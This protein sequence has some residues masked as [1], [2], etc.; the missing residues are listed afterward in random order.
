MRN[1][2]MDVAIH[3]TKFLEPGE[4]VLDIGSNDGTFLRGIKQIMPSVTTVGVE[5]AENLAEEGSRGVDLLYKEFWEPGVYE[6]SKPPKVIT[7]LGMLYDLED[8]NPFIAEVS[9]VLATDG[10]F[11]AQL[12]C[13]EDTVRNRD[14]GNFAH[15]HLEFYTL[16]SLMALYERHG[17]T[18][19][20]VSHNTVNG[21]SYRIVAQHSSIQPRQDHTLGQVLAREHNLL[22]T[23]S[24]AEFR[25][26][27]QRGR[28]IIRNFLLNAQ[29]SRFWVYGASTKGNVILQ[30]YGL[31]AQWIDG[32]AERSPEKYG[33]VTIGTEIP[34]VSE[35]EAREAN[36]EYFIVLP[37][38]FISEFLTRERPYLEG[39]GMFVVP[40]P[41]F[42]IY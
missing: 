12:M 8:P 31:N 1:A 3:A 34:I 28:M 36:P 20:S 25:N 9:K 24:I 42:T 17:L 2:L 29:E 23:S 18:I 19:T 27:V 39:G 32:A 26:R 30:Y 40:I 33:L 41:R 22:D 14:I 15:E 4:V 11:I 21:G 37:Y 38:A 6:Y 10:V 5:P 35:E 7:A 13:L 16:I